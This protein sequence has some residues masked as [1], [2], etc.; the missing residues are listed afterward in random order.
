MIYFEAGKILLGFFFPFVDYNQLTKKKKIQKRNYCLN[1]S[2]KI[3]KLRLVAL[4][5][6]SLCFFTG[7]RFLKQQQKKPVILL[8]K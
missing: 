8:L 7:I 1:K 5:K 6:I 2:K 3:G 4:C